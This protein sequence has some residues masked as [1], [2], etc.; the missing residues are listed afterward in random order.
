MGKALF[1]LFFMLSLHGF[2]DVILLAFRLPVFVWEL[3]RWCFGRRLS[4]EI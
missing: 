4:A 1:V 3:L 2:Y